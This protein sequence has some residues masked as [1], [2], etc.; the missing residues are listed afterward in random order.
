[1]YMNVC[2]WFF[3]LPFMPMF[4]FGYRSNAVGYCHISCCQIKYVARFPSNAH[5]YLFAI[6]IS[7]LLSRY[8]SLPLAISLFLARQVCAH[9]Y[10]IKVAKSR[11]FLFGQPIPKQM[12]THYTYDNARKVSARA[13]YSGIFRRPDK[14]NQDVLAIKHLIQILC[15]LNLFYF[16]FSAWLCFSCFYFCVSFF[17]FISLFFNVFLLCTVL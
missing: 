6:R 12:R 16:L 1:M 14:T 7:F 17:V 8:C 11:R 10:Q 9:P 3:G 13:S 15:A 2:M 4:V 5:L